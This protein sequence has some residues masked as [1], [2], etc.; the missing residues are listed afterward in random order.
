MDGQSSSAQFEW[1]WGENSQIPHFGKICGK[2][3]LFWKYLGIYH[4][5]S[6]RVSQ[7][8]VL[9][10]TRVQW[11]QVP[12]ESPAWHYWPKI[13]VIKKIMWYSILLKSSTFFIVLELHTVKYLVFLFFFF[14]LLGLVDM[15]P[16]HLLWQFMKNI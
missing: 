3:V 13:C 14:F 7:N 5:F 4:F 16:S 1:E 2:L 10:S 15:V 9:N 8:R 6:T 11:T 12:S